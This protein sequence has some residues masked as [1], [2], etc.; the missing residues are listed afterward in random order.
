[1]MHVQHFIYI[2]PLIFILTIKETGC[3][4]SHFTDEAQPNTDTLV[5]ELEFELRHLNSR[6]CECWSNEIENVSN[7]S[8]S[9]IQKL[10]HR[11]M[12][13]PYNSLHSMLRVFVL[14]QLGSYLLIL[15]ITHLFSSTLKTTYLQ[16]TP[17]VFCL[18]L[19][20]KRV[21]P[22]PTCNVCWLLIAH[23]CNFLWRIALE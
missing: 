15:P 13:V 4:C 16:Q 14:R 9:Q 6:V 3:S 12:Y 17:S 2:S 10:S 8:T 1:M 23:R 22:F 20:S 21:Y 5:G 7:F 11:Q 19:L 18:I